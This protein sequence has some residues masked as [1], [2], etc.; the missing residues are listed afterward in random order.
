MVEKQ[1]LVSEGQTKRECRMPVTK[2]ANLRLV[3]STFPNLESAKALSRELLDQKWIACVNIVPGLVSM[4]SWQGSINESQEVLC[5]FKTNHKLVDKVMEHVS[6]HHPYDC[7]EALSCS[8]T[9]GLPTYLE[10]L[11]ENLAR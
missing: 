7:P 1:T 11:G 9:E 5:L 2:S 4:Y 3:F 8:V 10:W 6:E